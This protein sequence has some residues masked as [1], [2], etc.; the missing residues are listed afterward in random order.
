MIFVEQDVA[1][2]HEPPVEVLERDP[3]HDL[4]VRTMTGFGGVVTFVLRTDLEGTSRA[5]D[6]CTLCT[7]A[8][9]LGGVETL[10]E[11]P[12]LMSHYELTPEQRAA[13]GIRENLVRLAVGIEDEADIREDLERALST[14]GIEVS[15]DAKIRRPALV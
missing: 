2:E 11:Q 7:I 14:V 13:I 9:S 4:A 6:A 12:A 3:D 15:G 10:I 1:V 8:P 5:L